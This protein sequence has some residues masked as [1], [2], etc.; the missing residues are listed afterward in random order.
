MP[1]TGTT[2]RAPFRSYPYLNWFGYSFQGGGYYDDE[3]RPV[4]CMMKSKSAEMEMEDK[5]M[6]YRGPHR[7]RRLPR[8]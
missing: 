8:K 1:A 5:E 3:V 4:Y 7:H 2:I 6:V